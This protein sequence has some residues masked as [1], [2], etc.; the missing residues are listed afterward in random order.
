M[1]ARHTVQHINPPQLDTLPTDTTIGDALEYMFQHQAAPVGIT[2]DGQVTGVVTYRSISRALLNAER[3]DQQDSVLNFPVETGL[4]RSFPQVTPSD[5]LF[6][7][8]DILSDARYVVVTAADGPPRIIRDV[9]FHQFLQTELEEFL[10]VKEIEHRLREL[11]RNEMESDLSERLHETFDQLEDLRTPDSLDH[12]SFRHYS[13]FISDHWTTVEHRF[14][15][16][17]DFVRDLINRVGDIR[18]QLFHFRGEGT[19]PDLGRD[20]LEFARDHFQYVH[21]YESGTTHNE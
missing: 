1:T 6:D 8:F 15:H 21:S 2:D 20:I 9:E 10:L 5:S 7:L 4:D 12:C 19:D 17:P 14:D 16:H 18:N 11:F 3:I 13:I